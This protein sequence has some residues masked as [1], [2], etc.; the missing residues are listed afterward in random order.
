V[1]WAPIHDFQLAGR[2]FPLIRIR[3]L[4]FLAAGALTTEK[5][6]WFT[7]QGWDRSNRPV[8]AG[9]AGRVGRG[10]CRMRKTI[11]T[12]KRQGA[13]WPASPRAKGLDI[14]SGSMSRCFFADRMN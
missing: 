4:P 8:L 5:K 1:L 6:R 13:E 14:L 10:E 2:G 12:V 3:F 7:A 11:A 9:L